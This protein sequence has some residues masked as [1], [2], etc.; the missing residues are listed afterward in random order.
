MHTDSYFK[1]NRIL[2]VPELYK[3]NACSLI[4]KALHSNSGSPIYV[5]ITNGIHSHSYETR[6][7]DNLSFPTYNLSKS[8]SSFLS[9]GISEWN[10]VPENIKSVNNV[11]NFRKIFRE[12]LLE[13]YIIF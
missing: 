2:R 11:L 12:Y 3:L 4:F 10:T 1:E 6:N 5:Q 8:M 13:S 7:R 9:R